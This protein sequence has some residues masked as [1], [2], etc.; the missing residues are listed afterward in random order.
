MQMQHMPDECEIEWN[1]YTDETFW[2]RRRLRISGS[3]IYSFLKAK[4]EEKW[5]AISGQIMQDFKILGLPK[6]ENAPERL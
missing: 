6:N 5:R 2:N 3:C 4:M 1:I